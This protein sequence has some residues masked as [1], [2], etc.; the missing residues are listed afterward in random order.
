MKDTFRK[1]MSKT[2]VCLIAAS[3]MVTSVQARQAKA[4]DSVEKVLKEAIYKNI[5]SNVASN[6]KFAGVPQKE[7]VKDDNANV[8]AEDPSEAVRV[9]VQLEAPAA[10]D[11]A[12]NG[13]ATMAQV[14][15][16]KSTQLKVMTEA[17]KIQGSKIRHSYGNLINGFSMEVKRGEIES[18]EKI[19]GVKKVTEAKNYYVDMNYSKELTQAKEVWEQYKYQGEGTLI[20]IIDTGIDH[21]HKD[22]RLDQDGKDKAKLTKSAVE[23]KIEELG[24]GTYLSDKVPF[25]Y[26]Y[27]DKNI[28][29]K[30]LTDSMHG[31]HVAGIAAANGEDSEVEKGA[32]VDGVAP[33]A[34]LL[35]MKVFSNGPGSSGAWTD[36][37]VA[38]IEDSVL[39]GADVINMSLGSN[40]GFM[41]PEDPEQI[42]VKRATDAGVSV[43]VSA[44][45]SQYSTAPYKFDSMKDIGVVG[46]PGVAKD[47]L[48][49]ANFENNNV[50]SPA[51]TLNV[52]GAK[53]GMFGYTQS[54]VPVS[55][56]FKADQQLEVVYC[57][58]GKVEDF[59]GKD[60]K[61]KI[62]LI[63]RGEIGF[64]D[65]KVN[66]Q[67]A[68]AAGV[69]VY[70]NAA[71]GESYISM[72]ANPD[73]K[74]P[75]VFVKRSSG[76]KIKEALDAKKKVALVFGNETV[77]E[78]NADAG[79]FD[80]ST[81][82]GTAPNLEFKPEI[83]A[84]GGDIYST[85][86]D[87]KYETMSGTSMAAPHATGGQAL[88]IQGI[89]KNNPNIKGRDLS[90]LARF[91]AI[92]TAQVRMDKEHP[93]TP[94]SPRRQGAGMMQI[95]NAIENSVILTYKKD[96]NA[97]T[98]LK[99]IGKTT[100]F[101]LQLENLGDKEVAYKVS[102]LGGVLTDAKLT[103]ASKMHYDV[104]LAEDQA[105]V[106]FSNNEVK[107]PAKGKT[108]VKV[109]LNVTDKV[110]LERFIE[111]FIKF[112][113]TGAPS[114]V[115]PYIGYYGD[116]SKEEI[117]NVPVWNFND[118]NF[119]P[120]DHNETLPQSYMITMFGDKTNY[121]GYEG[122][123]EDGNVTINP[124]DI[125]ISPNK[126]E[127]GDQIIPYL[128]HL[129]NAKHTEVVVLDK[130]GKELG[131][132]AKQS[133]IRRKVYNASNGSGKKVSGFTGLSWDGT[134]FN[135]ST[136]KYEVVKEGQ[137]T[138]DIRS[139]VDLVN[140][141]PQSFKVPVKVDL[142]APTVEI[143][144]I[145][146]KDGNVYNVQWKAE[147][148][149]SNI[150]KAG[151]ALAVNGEEIE[152]DDAKVSYDENTKTFS[153]NIVLEKGYESISVA[154]ADRAF[155]FGYATKYAET[156]E[157]KVVFDGFDGSTLTVTESQNHEFTGRLTK[158]PKVFKLNG[159][160]V[161]INKDLTFSHEVKLNEGINRVTFYLEDAAG[162]VTEYAIKVE[163]D[164]VD[165]MITLD[166]ANVVENNIYIKKGET[167]VTLNG[168]VSDNTMGYKFSINGKVILDTNNVDVVGHNARTFSEKV[169]V[170]VGDTIELKVTD[171]Y[172]H[173]TVRTLTVKEFKGWAKQA[174]G[175]WKYYDEAGNEVKNGWRLINSYWYYFNA[176][177][178]MA[179]GWKQ[180]N[181][182]W[183]YLYE[184]G[185][186][187]Q[188]WINLNGYWY[189]LH[190][191]GDMA[192]GWTNI[193]GHWY[194]FYAGGDMAKNTKIDGYKINA[195]GVRV[196]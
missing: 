21:N 145:A 7:E 140:A 2:L 31:M 76:L 71:G 158:Q 72:I 80:D 9:I 44:G 162:K 115:M 106:K 37:V 16:V 149:G 113:A 105:N 184:G 152:V 17:K 137:Y 111:G 138:I 12:E 20:S 45:N 146:K 131:Q 119:K 129:R 43:V 147:D 144:N 179:T 85:V 196:K 126:D 148:T 170:K 52:D 27:A 156:D 132:V 141:K 35:A 188:G 155:N 136:G 49:V 109:T 193:G 185:D 36:D 95:K 167:N 84:P 64:L 172:G 168:E 92:N 169:D 191:G 40:A 166:M 98:A 150:M 61:G 87:N 130:D 67:A 177:G 142:T 153:T 195:D 187:A 41:D 42:A 100:E 114:L 186:M 175:T 59:T 75:G 11:T 125:A 89:R 79:D 104:Q 108:T 164:T 54:D 24:R 66:A 19:P 107:V 46:S 123:D 1:G 50:T 139:S 22:M 134:I 30:D 26:N 83:S 48:Q 70:N 39:L 81:S 23:K 173:T 194:Y 58:L 117:I 174:N 38:A 165:P 62:A 160:D 97:V 25:G 4:E 157:T 47:T 56:A 90:R 6:D 176:D 3:T 10:A 110:E 65:K 151:Y 60:I 53:S 57:G 154:V 8:N 96:G 189:Y 122:K 183:Y 78:A 120:Q 14:D 82:W 63:E 116:W 112:E 99:E 181:G 68:G 190:K 74:I 180:V 88:I 178:T 118:P 18:L 93:D 192:T 55:V 159:K 133:N 34:Q 163:C 94:Y 135:K 101:E 86:N 15:A 13:R 171:A 32:A 29:A 28:T 51:L 161:T 121:L 182:H 128:Y 73:A 77:S 5:E 124:N 127:A 103:T 33:D 102:H 69:I 143:I 91:T